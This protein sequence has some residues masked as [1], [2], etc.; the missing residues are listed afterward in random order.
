MPRWGGWSNRRDAW[1]R[2]EVTCD[3]RH[4][5]GQVA[6]RP[7]IVSGVPPPLSFVTGETDPFNF[8]KIKPTKKSAQRHSRDL[9]TALRPT[10]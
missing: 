10:E 9:D 5:P 1:R 3:A 6:K 7:G 2:P 4:T 8:Q